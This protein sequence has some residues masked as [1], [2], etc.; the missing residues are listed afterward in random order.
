MDMKYRGILTEDRPLGKY[1]LHMLKRVDQP[2]N[3]YVGEI[4]RRDPS[5]SAF[6]RAASGEYGS[7]LSNVSMGFFGREPILASFTS[8]QEHIAKFDLPPVAEKKAPIPEDPKILA[9]H[10]KSFAYWAGADMIGICKLPQSALYLRSEDGSEIDCKLKYAIVLANVKHS[11]TIRSSYGREWIDDPTS[12]AV[13]QRCASQA[14][15]LTGYI[16]RL[17][18]AAEP[19]IFFKYLT[20]MPQLVIEAGLGEGSR[21]GIALNPFVGSTFKASAVLTDLPLEPDKPIDFGLQDYCSKCKICAE[22]CATQSISHGEKEV[23]NGYETWRLKYENCVTGILTNKYGNVCQRC[24]KVC[25]WNR[26]ENRPE[27]FRG[28]DGDLKSLHDSVNRQAEQLRANGFR[29]PEEYTDKWWFPLSY[30]DG[31]LVDSPEFDYAELDRRVELLNK[32]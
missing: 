18:W 32:K 28:W 19:S 25:P 14:Q 2:T 7:H 23:Y 13:Y 26:R 10:I 27:D 8:F 15:V 1:P 5:E 30:V 29:E 21:M 17:G 4:K 9:R 20:L 6:E 22:Q 11:E 24:A 3:K 16:R 31:D 12:F